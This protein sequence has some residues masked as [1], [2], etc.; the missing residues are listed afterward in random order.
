MGQPIDYLKPVGALGSVPG[1]SIASKGLAKVLPFSTAPLKRVTRNGL[2]K[3]VG[4]KIARK[5]VNKVIGASVV[6]RLIGRFVP[7]VG[8]TAT[9][10]DAW[11]NR[12]EI[13]QAAAGFSM[14]AGYYY[15]LRANPETGWMYV[16]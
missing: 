13:G 4:K 16:K 10:Y 1:S 11:E 7:Y 9:A 12:S 15:N 6:G 3:V 8:W 5:V 14:G 2:T